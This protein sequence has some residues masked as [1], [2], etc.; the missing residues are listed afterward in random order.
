MDHE[1]FFP[2]EFSYAVDEI[3]YYFTRTIRNVLLFSKSLSHFFFSSS[4]LVIFSDVYF[5]HILNV[6]LKG[7]YFH[8]KKISIIW[9][10]NSEFDGGHFTVLTKH[11]FHL[12]KT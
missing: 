2:L 12:E 11:N 1:C 7:K 4:T 9:T 3:E 8:N 5:F 6:K 10:V